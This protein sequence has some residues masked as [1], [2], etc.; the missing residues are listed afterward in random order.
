MF[1]QPAVDVGLGEI[2]ERRLLTRSAFQHRRENRRR[3]IEMRNRRVQYK[4][5]STGQINTLRHGSLLL[6]PMHHRCIGH[7]HPRLAA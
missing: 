6:H 4:V 2:G 3:R 7:R 1:G 5:H